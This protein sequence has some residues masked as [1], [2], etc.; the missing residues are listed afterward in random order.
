MKFYLLLVL[1][2]GFEAFADP[3]TEN[4]QAVASGPNAP[5]VCDEDLS[6]YSDDPVGLPDNSSRVAWDATVIPFNMGTRPVGF[7]IHMK[8]PNAMAGNPIDPAESVTRDWRFVSKNGSRR[9][10]YISLTDDAG[11]GKLS[12]LMESVIVLIPRKGRPH[13][14]R[15]GD[16]NIVTLTT[17]EQVVFNAL[18]NTIVSGVLTERPV[19]L[20]PDRFK[21][22]FAQVSYTGAGIS[23]RADKRGEEPRL[24]TTT[25]TVTQQGKSCQVPAADL[26]VN[27]STAFKFNNDEN[28]LR[29]LNTKCPGKF[30]LP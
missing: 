17:G 22:K 10:T 14:E 18:T 21:R 16:Q 28:L 15:V 11:S 1:F 8:G 3:L 6:F 12:Q 7:E 27:P 5:Y 25:A 4:L 24:I 26:W 23:I 2:S 29:Y 13:I 30:K 19:D 20:N 9:E